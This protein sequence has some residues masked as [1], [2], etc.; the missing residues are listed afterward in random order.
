MKGGRVCQMEMKKSFRLEL[1]EQRHSGMKSILL[2]NEV[3]RTIAYGRVG[4][5]QV[6]LER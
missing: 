4:K 2:E 3:R 6:P 5:W 1:R